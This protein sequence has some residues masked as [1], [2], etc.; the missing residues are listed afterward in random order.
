MEQNNR[1]I[2]CFSPT[3]G[4]RTIALAIRNDSDSFINFTLPQSRVNLP[5]FS[6]SSE[7]VF[8][9]PVYNR[10]VPD[11]C[12]QYIKKLNGKNAGASVICVYGGVTKGNALKTAAK[13]LQRSNFN[14]K[15]GAYIAAPHFYSNTKLNN[16]SAERLE[17]IRAFLNGDFSGR[18][19]SVSKN[20][21]SASAVSVQPLMKA[22]TGKCTVN[23]S[24]C[25][26][27]GQCLNNCPAD[28]INSDFKA[29]GN[30]IL[31]GA[32][33]NTCPQHARSIRFFSPLPY[34]FIKANCKHRDDE[35]FEFASVSASVKSRM[36]D[37]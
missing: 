23:P 32:C 30:C 7:V 35:F 3:G 29:D 27:C 4:C 37:H 9:I 13:L 28:A 17:R 34:L 22:L 20:A 33:V 11:I 21:H 14:V 1:T 8:V 15:K 31:C 6:Q 19:I 16:L 24:A 12:A 10:S 36:L 5:S 26:A 18:I 25:T 2:L